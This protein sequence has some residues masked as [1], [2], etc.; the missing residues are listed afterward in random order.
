MRLVNWRKVVKQSAYNAAMLESENRWGVKNN[1][2]N[3]RWEH[4]KEVVQLA[5]KL[6]FNLKADMDIVEAA[7]WLHDCAKKKTQDGHGHKGGELAKDILVNTDFPPEKISAVSY[8]IRKHVGLSL[9]KIITPIEAAILW[10]ADK[11]VKLGSISVL[12]YSGFWFTT[13]QGSLLELIKNSKNL[14]WAEEIVQSLNTPIAKQ[15]GERRLYTQL[16]FWEQI[17]RE[18]MG[19]DIDN[20]SPTQIAA[21]LATPMRYTAK[22]SRFGSGKSGSQSKN[23]KSPK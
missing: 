7:A 23:A 21:D 3:Y 18:Y 12:H 5:K 8:T 19:H 1:T 10:D 2:F 22:K 13:E 20:S 14:Q 9:D 15:V 16:L 11:L 6:T 4:V 17:N